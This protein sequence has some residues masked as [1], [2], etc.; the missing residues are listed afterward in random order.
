MSGF[1]AIQRDALE[2]PLLQDPARFRAWVWLIANAAWKST[3]VRIKGETIHLERGELSFAQ[4]FLAEKWGMS[5]SRVDRFIADLRAEGM[6]ETRS[7][8]G[9]DCAHK[10]GQGQSII[11]IC[12]YDKYQ[13]RDEG[14]RGNSGA[15][16]GAT[17]G[18]QRG[19]E[20]Q[21]N[22]GTSLSNERERDSA[23]AQDVIDEW[24]KVAKPLRLSCW[25]KLTPK[26]RR[27]INSRLAD[28]GFEAIV[29]AIE[30]VPKSAFL[31]GDRGDWNGADLDF[32]TRPD[33]VQKILEGKYDDRAKQ[34]GNSGGGRDSRDGVAKALDRRLGLG[35][36]AGEVDRRATGGGGRIGASPAAFL[37][38]L[39]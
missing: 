27:L 22:K 28:Y 16:R 7:K 30:H 18:Q 32:L 31:R 33:S 8:I 26:R 25:E 9:A 35:P 2:H 4:R 10:A 13:S 6:I 11:T 14:E 29:Q 34:N 19:K 12:N 5:K 15:T 17:A 23:G 39:R 20:E 3:S 36:D 1:I 37:A 38:D 24:R 21:G